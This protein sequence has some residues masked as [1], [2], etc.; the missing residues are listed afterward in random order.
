MADSA[1]ERVAAPGPTQ[2]PL[3]HAENAARYERQGQIAAYQ[4][5]FGCRLVVVFDAIFQYSVNVFED[6]VYDADPSEDLHVLLTTPGG[7]GEAAL[8]L[9]RSMQAHCRE[10][11]VIVPDMAK[12]AGTI[13]ALGSHQILMGPSSDL[14][15]VD[16]QLVAN[17]QSQ[18]LISAKDV[19]AAV[20]E[21]LASVQ[22]NPET[23]PL[24]ASLL[25]NLNAIMLQQARSALARTE[26]LVIEALSSSPARSKEEAQ[27]LWARSLKQRLMVDPRSHAATFGP[28][29]ALEA[30]LPVVRPD[31]GGEQW[32]MIWR[33]WSK[34]F[35]LGARI[36]EGAIASKVVGPWVQ[37]APSQ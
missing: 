3:Y 17:P 19:I 21:A 20:E 9:L 23:Y 36:Y 32:A 5:R 2:S 26:D 15:P 25:S 13:I 37:P 31:P 33:L 16:P 30:G 12:S 1:P 8:R 4:R 34:Y 11:S 35:V 10:L 7:D 18:E 29:A 28:D 27:A 6:L 24:Q 22:A 14:G